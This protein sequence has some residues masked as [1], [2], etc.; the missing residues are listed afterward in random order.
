M[1]FIKNGPDIPSTLLHAHEEGNVVF[2]C[3]SG[4]SAPAGLGTFEWLVGEIYRNLSTEPEGLE[5]TPYKN[6]QYDTTLDLQE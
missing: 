5:I 4:I 2:F 1:Q 3:G 6:K